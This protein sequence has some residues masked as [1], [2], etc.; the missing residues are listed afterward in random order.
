MKYEI[1]IIKNHKGFTLRKV[2]NEYN[3][4]WYEIRFV[5][6]NNKDCTTYVTYEYNDFNKASKKANELMGINDL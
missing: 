3:D 6:G 4:I 1:N 5:S 2:T